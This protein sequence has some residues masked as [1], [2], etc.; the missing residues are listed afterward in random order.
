MFKYENMV[1]GKMKI[2]E[3]WNLYSNVNRWSEWDTDIQNVDL[4]G[5]FVKGT[6]GTMFM[7]G[8]PPL[9]FTLDVVEKGEKFINSSSLGDIAVQFGH[10]I[11]DEGN[12][13]YTLKHTVQITGS[14]DNKL[15]GIGQGIVANIPISM[16]KLFQLA[17]IESI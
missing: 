4:E 14:D 9:A 5:M 11:I 17:S 1:R 8:M 2:E 12:N 16:E 6:K 7:N 13:E 3:V 10:Y 15:Q